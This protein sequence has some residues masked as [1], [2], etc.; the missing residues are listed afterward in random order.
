MKSEEGRQ[1]RKKATDKLLKSLGEKRNRTFSHYHFNSLKHSN[2]LKKK[3][4]KISLC[5]VTGDQNRN[6]RYPDEKDGGNGGFGGAGGAQGKVVDE[7]EVLHPVPEE[8][9]EVE[10][11]HDAQDEHHKGLDF[12]L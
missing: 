4:R 10:E 3:E 7:G 2:N 12:R 8:E 5:S 1:G 6:F 11:Y 9:H